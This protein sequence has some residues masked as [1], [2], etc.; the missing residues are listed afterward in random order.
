MLKLLEL[1][2]N[3]TNVNTHI[4]KRTA[5]KNIINFQ[6]LRN[7]EVASND[8]IYAQP[9]IYKSHNQRVTLGE[10]SNTETICDRDSSPTLRIY[11]EIYPMRYASLTNMIKEQK[12]DEEDETEDEENEEE[13]KDR[14]EDEALSKVTRLW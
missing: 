10:K 1:Y 3:T 2:K 14:R 11:N 13:Q 9:R 4:Y 5:F 7:L 8:V 12:I 6:S